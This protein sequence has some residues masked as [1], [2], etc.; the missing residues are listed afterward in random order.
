VNLHDPEA[1]EHIRQG[2]IK[3][4]KGLA[5]KAKLTPE[6]EE[7]IRTIPERYPHFM[8]GYV[9]KPQKTLSQAEQEAREIV[10]AWSARFV[11]TRLNQATQLWHTGSTR[12]RALSVFT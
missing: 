1:D 11:V 8:Q 2:L 4:L 12:K 10:N 3:Y 6:Q 9:Q 5:G 7:Q